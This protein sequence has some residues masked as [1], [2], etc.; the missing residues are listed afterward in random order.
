MQEKPVDSLHGFR[1]L[2]IDDELAV[3][4]AVIAEE[5]VKWNRHLAVRESL[6]LS[7]GAVLGNAPG[8]LLRNAAHDGDEQLALAVEGPDVFFL[9]IAL[10]AMLFEFPDGGQA[11]DCV[12]GE[13]A[14]GLGENDVELR[15]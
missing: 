15:S 5:S 9:E 2:R 3:W 7:P 4:S 11:V 13:P 12:P 10:N 8:F 6:P 14:D 1:F